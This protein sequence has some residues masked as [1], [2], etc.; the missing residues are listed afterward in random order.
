MAR[1]VQVS[2]ILSVLLVGQQVKL[3]AAGSKYESRIK[4]FPEK[5]S[6]SQ[7]EEAKEAA[8]NKLSLT[9]APPQSKT[10]CISGGTDPTLTELTLKHLINSV[11]HIFDDA[12]VNMF[13]ATADYGKSLVKST[14]PL[15][16]FWSGYLNVEE[17]RPSKIWLNF[18]PFINSSHYLMIT[19][20]D[21]VP[22]PT[23]EILGTFGGED[24]SSTIEQL[25]C[26]AKLKH[27]GFKFQPWDIQDF[28][29]HM[30]EMH[31]KGFIDQAVS[32]SSFTEEI[33]VVRELL[34]HVKDISEN[35]NIE[36]WCPIPTSM[37]AKLQAMRK[38]KLY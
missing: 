33:E 23:L 36:E 5:W 38:F 17:T 34:N 26:L 4:Y 3:V 25:K 24:L 11:F 6:R 16:L 9:T 7:S 8:L 15:V 29:D 22:K 1:V 12:P 2:L 28:R 21:T 30:N 27:L 35:P 20:A 37:L 18:P 13:Y 19:Y 31:C 14:D 32:T 10:A